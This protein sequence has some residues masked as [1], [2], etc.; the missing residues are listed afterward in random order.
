MRSHLTAFGLGA[1]L[2]LLAG[3]VLAVAGPHFI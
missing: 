3:G 1:G 2:V